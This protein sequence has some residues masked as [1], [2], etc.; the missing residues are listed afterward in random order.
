MLNF[1]KATL[2]TL[3]KGLTLSMRAR[4]GNLI[5]RTPIARAFSVFPAGQAKNGSQTTTA[6]AVAAAKKRLV[7]QDVM[8][9]L[10]ATARLAR[11]NP[12]V[13]API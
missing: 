3:S 2:S 5:V 8:G 4:G 7:A 6:W 12:K 13:R 1:A 9:V 10:R 11:E